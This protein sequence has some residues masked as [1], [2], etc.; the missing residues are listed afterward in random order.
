[1]ADNII[2]RTA[3][4][5]DIENI[6]SCIR[7]VHGE[8]YNKEYYAPAYLRTI[9]NNLFL[10]AGDG[11]AAGMMELAAC[12]YKGQDSE[13][14]TYM[15]RHDMR[16][17]KIG[18]SLIGFALNNVRERGVAEAVKAGAVTLSR[19]SQR[20]AGNFGFVASGMLYGQVF[21]D[22]GFGSSPSGRVFRTKKQALVMLVKNPRGPDAGVLHLPR[23][24]VPAALGLYK[25]LGVGFTLGKEH[26]VNGGGLSE[27]LLW[28]NA[29]EQ[30]RTL[31]IYISRH[32][33]DFADRLREL[34]R[35]YAHPL[36]TMNFFVD[37][38]SPGAVAAYSELTENGCVFAGFAPLCGDREYLIMHLP[39]QVPILYEEVMFTDRN[40]KALCGI[41]GSPFHE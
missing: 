30:F 11:D 26:P 28:H 36:L 34:M 33:R 25:N 16:R 2:Y 9:L 35:T 22:D 32:G 12:G 39:G 3:A 14:H 23:A 17:R 19:N 5:G 15:V 37:M 18:E 38:K 21:L 13:L 31:D 8:T 40:R 10:A 41:L 29:Y 27:S 24:L 20:A 7:D 1:M 4:P 6:V